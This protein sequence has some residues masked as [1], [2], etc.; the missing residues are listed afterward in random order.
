[1]RDPV[2]GGHHH[3][4][5]QINNIDRV[6]GA[7][8][9]RTDAKSEMKFM[10]SSFHLPPSLNGHHHEMATG[11]V[12]QFG[13]VGL[14][15]SASSKQHCAMFATLVRV[16]PQEV[17]ALRNVASTADCALCQ[18]TTS[19]TITIGRTDN[20]DVHEFLAPQTVQTTTTCACG[21]GHIQ[22][23]RNR[24]KTGVRKSEGTMHGQARSAVD[25]WDA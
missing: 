15:V 22:R 21:I 18:A 9:L 24:S 16:A 10:S 5:H 4:N 23:S 11:P 13:T 19:I 14:L 3:H 6:W 1:M 2:Q 25:D 8:R 12:N 7:S 20:V 17:V